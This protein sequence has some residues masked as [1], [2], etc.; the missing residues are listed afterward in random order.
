MVEL[1]GAVLLTKLLE[2]VR[3]TL[4]LHDVPIYGWID[5]TVALASNNIHQSGKPLWRIAFPTFKLEFLI[6]NGITSIQG[7]IPSFVSSEVY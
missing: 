2:H 5:S 3:C 4:D 7:P 1:S 6:S